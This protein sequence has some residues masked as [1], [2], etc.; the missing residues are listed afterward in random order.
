[1][2]IFRRQ[3]EPYLPDGDYLTV[4]MPTTDVEVLQVLAQQRGVLRR[5]STLATV[6]N[7]DLDLGTIK[8][9]WDQPVVDVKGTATR[10]ARIG[11]GA[12]VV[13][14]LVQALGGGGIGAELAAT[15]AR[16]VEFGY[17]DVVADR[18]DLGSLDLW[19]ASADLNPVSHA[20]ADLLVAETMFA[21]VGTLKARA[22]AVTLLDSNEQ[23]IS[24]DVPVIAEAAGGKIAVGRT[25]ESSATLT[26]AGKRPLV[27]AAKAAQLK[28]DPE[29]GFWVSDRLRTKGEIRR[30][31]QE[32][33]VSYLTAADGTLALG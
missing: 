22:I 32:D 29:R 21:V 9:E 23:S 30:L 20:I 18:V 33:D 8:V 28:S 14:S 11:L 12:S 15:G 16:S 4:T 6:L 3:A 13:A 7:A 10:K 26:F 17:A 5:F 1:M 19:L 24:V 25:G 31:G 2:A 27:V